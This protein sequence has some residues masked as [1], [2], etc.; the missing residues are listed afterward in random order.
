MRTAQQTCDLSGSVFGRLR[1]IG[2]GS[3]KNH[4]LCEC[5]CGTQKEIYRS[6]I[7]SGKTVSCGCRRLEIG[8]ENRTH[9]KTKSREYRIWKQMRSR[10]E[11]AT[12]PDYANWGGRGIKVCDRWQSFANFLDD[13]GECPDGASIDRFP[14]N[15][16]N[17][18]P[19]N[20]RWATYTEQARNKTNN[21]LLTFNGETACIAEWSE[22]TGISQKLI[23]VRILGGWSV[24]DALSLP[25]TG[26]HA[27]KLI[28]FNGRRMGLAAWAKELGIS[29][30][31]LHSRFS[32]GWSI[33]RAL[34]K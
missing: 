23:R 29:K 22:R 21:H 10:C 11:R 13:M 18:E 15:N 24:E 16:G 8:K 17:Y 4:L 3:R 27:D 5:S 28:E 34:S 31:G 32:R 20:C 26:S 14:D 19:G 12:S 30:T 2:R 9:G 7:T 25:V 1:V 6:N 33:E